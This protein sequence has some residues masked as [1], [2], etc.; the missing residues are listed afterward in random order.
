MRRRK[1]RPTEKKTRL[2]QRRSDAAKRIN[3]RRPPYLREARAVS[4]IRHPGICPLYEI[5]DQADSSLLLSLAFIEGETLGS[6]FSRRAPLSNVQAADICAKIAQAVYQAHQ[7][8]VLHRDFKSQNILMSADDG[9]PVVTD[10]GLARR[11][12]SEDE[13]LTQD[14]AIVGTPAYM[15]PEQANGE[16]E[17]LNVATDIYSLGVI[18]YESLAGRRPFVGKSLKILAQIV[19]DEPP[20]LSK[21]NPNVDPELEA[22][23]Q[24][25]MAKRPGDRYAEMKDFAAALQDFVSA[26]VGESDYLGQTVLQDGK[27]RPAHHDTALDTKHIPSLRRV[28]WG[29]GIAL[30]V[31]GLMALG[32]GWGGASSD[33]QTETVSSSSAEEES[34]PV[35]SGPPKPISRFAGKWRIFSSLL[36][37]EGGLLEILDTGKVELILADSIKSKSA[38]AE[39][40]FFPDGKNDLQGE[41]HGHKTLFTA[42]TQDSGDNRDGPASRPRVPGKA[43]DFNPA[44]RESRVRIR[45]EVVPQDSKRPVQIHG[46]EFPATEAVTLA[47]QSELVDPRESFPITSL[48]IHE[49]ERWDLTSIDSDHLF[50]HRLRFSALPGPQGESGSLAIS[51]DQIVLIRDSAFQGN[52][53]PPQHWLLQQLWYTRHADHGVVS[54]LFLPDGQLILQN[55]ARQLFGGRNG[56]GKIHLTYRALE[57]SEDALKIEVRGRLDESLKTG[58]IPLRFGAPRELWTCELID[59][60]EKSRYQRDLEVVKQ[61]KVIEVRTRTKQ[62]FKEVNGEQVPTEVNENYGVEI[63]VEMTMILKSAP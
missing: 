53:L 25:A 55:E 51:F 42:L 59:S 45:C 33:Q 23:C 37:D 17:S 19:N 5:H 10:F 30:T 12:E 2:A 11:T 54:Y 62:V 29:V 47:L 1:R 27:S 56:L 28:W 32:F 36:P 40:F 63:P 22:I 52:P 8:G 43:A 61:T 26:S 31:V 15:S 18:L 35:A 16:M 6:F 49:R 20:R 34:S 50:G 39:P 38:R 60:S 41:S 46:F 57:K 21:I 9:Q 3:I 13:T 14:G 44:L 24:T 58:E 48:S 7:R 4:A